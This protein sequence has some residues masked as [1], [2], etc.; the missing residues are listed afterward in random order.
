[1]NVNRKNISDL[2]GI[3]A[4]VNLDNLSCHYNQLTKLDLSNNP[5]GGQLPISITTLP[6]LKVLEVRFCGLKR[7]PPEI[8][9]LKNLRELELSINKINRLPSE[10][11][12]LENLRVLHLESNPL[13]SLP[14]EFA[15]LTNLRTLYVPKGLANHPVL[16]KMQ[17]SQKLRLII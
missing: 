15:K 12:L 4:F 16:K 11:G 10:I 8:G 13:N 3:E 17:D 5:L 14:S 9:R 1:M 2:T 6:S 7:L